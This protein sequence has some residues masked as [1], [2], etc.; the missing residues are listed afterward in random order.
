MALTK[1]TYSMIEGTPVNA[2]DFGAVGDGVTNDTAAVQAA[3]DF[4][5]IDPMN[6]KTLIISGNHYITQPLEINTP[7]LI[8]TDI[9]ENYFVMLGVGKSVGFTTDQNIVLFT[10]DAFTGTQSVGRQI[11][12]ENLSFQGASLAVNCFV[13]DGSFIQVHSDNCEFIRMPFMNVGNVNTFSY[14]FTNCYIANW[15]RE[16][17]SLNYLTSND[18][19]FDGC[20]FNASDGTDFDCIH[21]SL[22]QA[23]KCVNNTFETMNGTPIVLKGAR[24]ANISGNYFEACSR[25]TSAYY[26]N[27]NELG[28][29]ELAG[30]FIAGNLFYFEIVQDADLGFYAINWDQISAGSSNG[31]WCTGKLHRIVNPQVNYD[32]SINGDTESTTGLAAGRAPIRSDRYFNICRVNSVRL[33]PLAANPSPAFEGQLYYNSVSKKAFV[34]N[35]TIWNALF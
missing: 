19:M 28:S 21:L 8:V 10:A 33:T 14:W 31:N 29:G 22:V 2:S 27:L 34:Y 1:V 9:R 20:Y 26:I 13:T 5:L 16:F 23:F 11:R 30:V 24:S 7:S 4:C 15:Q 18:I 17:F 25:D 12:W 35:G 32:L 6:P 3:I